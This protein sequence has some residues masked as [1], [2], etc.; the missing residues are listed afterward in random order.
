MQKTLCKLVIPILLVLCF[1]GGNLNAARFVRGDVN[2]DGRHSL[3]DPI[4]LLIAIFTQDV[5]LQCDDAADFNDNGVLDIND[6]LGF[7]MWV[8]S[9]G[10]PP[11]A[12]YPECGSDPTEIDDFACREYPVCPQDPG[13]VLYSNP[14]DPT[15]AFI[16][17]G[18]GNIVG[19]FG[20]KDAQG[21]PQRIT[22]IVV[23]TEES[24][25]VSFS[26]DA[27]ERISAVNLYG[28]ESMTFDWKSATE[29][30]ITAFDGTSFVTETVILE[31]PAG[32][33]QILTPQGPAPPDHLAKG[34]VILLCE[35]GQP[36]SEPG[37]IVTVRVRNPEIVGPLCEAIDLDEL[38][39]QTATAINS[40][41][42]EY[43]LPKAPSSSVIPIDEIC[44]YMKQNTC[45]V[46]TALGLLELCRPLMNPSAVAVCTAATTSAEVVC[47]VDSLFD[48]VDLC[49]D[50]INGVVDRFQATFLLEFTV[51]HPR[52]GGGDCHTN[53]SPLEVDPAVRP[54]PDQTI[55]FPRSVLICPSIVI[56][57]GDLY[58]IVIEQ[59][60]ANRL[61]SH[62]GRIDSGG[63]LTRIG[64]LPDEWAFSFG[65]SPDCPLAIDGSGNLYTH[66][67]PFDPD[68]GSIYKMNPQGVLTEIPLVGL[69]S[70]LYFCGLEVR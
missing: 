5:T 10:N 9:T 15:I 51:S 35:Q 18:E 49:K 44:Q 29:V 21:V 65:N 60:P 57:G 52:C 12:P 61:I 33:S 27:M 62:I 66:P 41:E 42:F 47:V 37:A 55:Q 17:D 50:L 70:V 26:F 68:F 6:A 34:K 40:S 31:Q 58:T 67:P 38:C 59:G 46:N 69:G 16:D 14:G 36:V 64:E 39:Q 1:S 25:P 8:F 32:G 3:A 54:I 48:D 7:L 56:G 43:V 19:Y 53:L 30:E 20:E 2:A 11:N 23:D 24:D 45:G 28:G 4:T 63:N 22:R 13:I